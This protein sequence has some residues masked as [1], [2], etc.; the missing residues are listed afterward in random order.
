MLGGK[1][2][3]KFMYFF[4]RNDKVT[5]ATNSYTAFPSTYA[6]RDLRGQPTPHGFAGHFILAL[7]SEAVF[8]VAF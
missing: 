3:S 2:S 7:Q 5:L 4:N 1:L 6:L 8:T